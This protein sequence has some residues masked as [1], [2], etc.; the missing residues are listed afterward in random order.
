MDQTGLKFMVILCSPKI[1]GLPITPVNSGPGTQGFVQ[2]I[3]PLLW[4]FSF[5][6]YLFGLFCFVLFETGYHVAQADLDLAM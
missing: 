5:V 2:T 4:Y 6:F 1:L 3:F